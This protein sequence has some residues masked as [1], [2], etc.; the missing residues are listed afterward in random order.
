MKS[1]TKTKTFTL[2][3]LLVVI[4]II[5]ILAALLLPALS[6]ARERAEFICCTS[7]MKQINLAVHIYA[8]DN[9]GYVPERYSANLMTYAYGKSNG[10]TKYSIAALLVKGYLPGYTKNSD[11]TE[12]I[13]VK[14]LRCPTVADQLG[15]PKLNATTGI[16]WWMGDRGTWWPARCLDRF[17]GTA[18]QKFLF[19]DIMG[20]AYYNA[21]TD[22]SNHPG[23]GNWAGADGSVRAFK[24]TQMDRSTVGRGQGIG[25]YIYYPRQ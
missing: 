15:D 11:R 25:I 19:G 12:V 24:L 14:I 5:A 21:N 10:Q 17:P 7:N 20:P 22:M 13:D 16:I 23:R 6:Q 4:A 9:K 18:A 8:N 1:K 3:E 2:I